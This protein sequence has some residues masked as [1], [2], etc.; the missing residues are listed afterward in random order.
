MS[1]ETYLVPTDGSDPAEAA[2]ER[3]FD[4]AAQCNASIHVLSVA[5]DSVWAGIAQGDDTAEIRERLHERASNRALTLRKDAQDRGLDA[6]VAVRTGTPADEIVEY[7]STEPI[8]AI[9]MGT[10]GRGG[11]RRAIVGSVADKV[12]R[13]APV[14]VMT[15]NT[16]TAEGDDP[17]PLATPTG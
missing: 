3:A 2:A 13:T 5:D 15:V 1:F 17:R 6:I 12:V 14:P 8:D 16:T 10:A 4:L 9:V 7:A 11:L